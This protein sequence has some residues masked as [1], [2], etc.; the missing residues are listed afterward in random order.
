MAG[1]WFVHTVQAKRMWYFL[2]IDE[3][4]LRALYIY[5]Y[6]YICKH[7]FI[8]V[9]PKIPKL[10]LAPL[11]W[12]AASWLL[13]LST[14]GLHGVPVFI[15]VA[16][17][18]E[19]SCFESLEHWKPVH[20]APPRLSPEV[21]LVLAT[22]KTIKGTEDGMEYALYSHRGFSKVGD[23]S[24]RTCHC[25]STEHFNLHSSVVVQSHFDKLS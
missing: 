4:S 19:G 22:L 24:I 13:G 15:T 21:S 11:L 23:P 3:D 5:I 6:I 7:I 20:G 1:G 2:F 14:T 12:W 10:S 25:L 8:L 16:W 17:Q 9:L 18:Q